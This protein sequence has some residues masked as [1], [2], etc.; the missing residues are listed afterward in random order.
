MSFMQASHSV[1]L[2]VARWL[3]LEQDCSWVEVKLSSVP[4]DLMES[5]VVDESLSSTQL[6]FYSRENQLARNSNVL[7]VGLR[8]LQV[9]WQPYWHTLD[10]LPGSAAK[11]LI[12][13]QVLN[14]KLAAINCMQQNKNLMLFY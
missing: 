3:S 9:W 8:I 2:I 13:S 12:L 10:C 5:T 6:Q 7:V 1:G 14:Q 4:S 11:S